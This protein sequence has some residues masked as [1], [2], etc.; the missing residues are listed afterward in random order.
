LFVG[1]SKGQNP[2]DTIQLVYGIPDWISKNLDV[3][4]FTNGDTIHEVQSSKEWKAAADNR[5][6]AWCYYNNDPS[7]REKFGKLYNW[8]AVND[9]RGLAPKGWHIPSDYEW[10]LLTKYLGEQINAETPVKGRYAWEC[11]FEGTNSTKFA[12]VPGGFR[13]AFG[14][15]HGG[16]SRGYW[17]SAPAENDLNSNKSVPVSTF[18]RLLTAYF[19]S[20]ASHARG[21]FVHFNSKNVGGSQRSAQQDKCLRCGFSVRCFKD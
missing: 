5:L 21:N 13:S 20:L 12:G 18:V 19:L 8:Y 2:L 17:W 7:N 11:N 4:T 9:I 3:S 15:F 16:G 10:S 6:P 1:V 14:A